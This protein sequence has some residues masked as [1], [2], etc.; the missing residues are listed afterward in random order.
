MN[1]AITTLVEECLVQHQGG[2]AFFD[3][4][5]EKLRND[6]ALLMMMLGRVLEKENFDYLI[7]SGHFGE[8][9]SQ[10]CKD[11]IPELENSVI[12]VNGGLRHDHEMI[13]FWESYP[14]AN[15]H[16]I[17]LDDSYYL[18][19][20]HDKIKNAIEAHGGIF[21]DTYVF[22]DGSK[23]KDNSVHSFYR[24]YDYFPTAD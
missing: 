15:K 8:V 24:Y 20:T 17:F 2:E 10:F 14:T 11:H 9:F 3:A 4:I 1:T 12:V 22:Y 23:L 6:R 5:D 13:P 7:V 19:R 18:G 16:F 21:N